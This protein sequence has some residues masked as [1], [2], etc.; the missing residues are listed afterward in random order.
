MKTKDIEMIVLSKYEKS[1]GTTKIFQDL[2][3]TIS[4]STLKQWCRRIRRSDSINLSKS[5]GRPRII[6]TKEAIEK[7]KT[8]LNRCNLM[9]S[10][11]LTSDL[12][13]S[14]S[15]VQR[16]LKNDLK[17]QA[18]KMQNE[19]MLT[20]EHKAKKI[21]IHKLDTSKFLKRRHH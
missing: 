17:L 7:V 20:D 21:K 2:N 13:I 9:S 11:K 10:G 18:Y 8:P 5:P 19:S 12:G 15:S 6:R 16:I 1:D 3:G 14:R 4:V